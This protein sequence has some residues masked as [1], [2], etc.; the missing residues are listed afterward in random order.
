MRECALCERIDRLDAHRDAPALGDGMHRIG[1]EI[2]DNLVHLRRI[3]DHVERLGCQGGAQLDSLGNR[4]AH[5][6]ERLGDDAA[7]VH[8]QAPAALAPAIGEYLIDERARTLRRG[9]KSPRRSRSS[10]Q[11]HSGSRNGSRHYCCARRPTFRNRLR[12][13]LRVR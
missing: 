12:R 5:E 3:G 10:G 9:I 8:R 6:V 11:L 4:A 7:E 2:H 1:A 13:H